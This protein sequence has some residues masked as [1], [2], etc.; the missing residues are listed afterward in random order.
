MTET[1]K[2]E[3]GI[4]TSRIG[5]TAKA[6]LDI[7][8]YLIFPI[9]LFGARIFSGLEYKYVIGLLLIYSIGYPYV[10]GELNK[11]HVDFIYYILGMVGLLMIWSSLQ[12]EIEKLEWQLDNLS[13]KSDIEF[14]E[15][16]RNT[17]VELLRN[18]NKKQY[19]N[20][21]NQ[22]SSGLIV[23]RQKREYPMWRETYNLDEN[24]VRGLLSD[25][26]KGSSKIEI[27]KSIDKHVA[28]NREKLETLNKN[29]PELNLVGSV[30]MKI[31]ILELYLWPVILAI[32]LSL[33]LARSKII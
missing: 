23:Y 5:D 16:A 7:V 22:G 33:K 6:F 30:N 29:R 21:L 9:L 31:R 2:E 13:H 11:K 1:K 4:K 10:V 25:S 24:Q 19:Q 32:A 14:Y 26:T 17:T 27:L 28:S 15:A 3:L 20:M 8:I 12:T 18:D